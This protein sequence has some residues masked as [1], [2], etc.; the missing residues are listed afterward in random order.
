M[1]R[2]CVL[3]WKALA[4]ALVLA[5][6]LSLLPP[7]W[8]HDEAPAVAA[9]G[10]AKDMPRVPIVE[11]ADATFFDQLATRDEWFIDFYADWCGACRHFAPKLP[12]L[13]ERLSDADMAHVGLG[14]VEIEHN[15]NLAARFMITRLPTLVYI[16]NGQIRVYEGPLEAVKIFEFIQSDWKDAEV[17]DG[18][19]SPFSTFGT[20][21]GKVA[22]GGHRIIG[23]FKLVPLWGYLLICIALP[24]AAFYLLARDRPQPVVKKQQ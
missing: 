20:V 6:A 5:L 12:R 21:I 9:G 19:F 17:W 8:A 23:I 15:P 10:V 2:A 13:S 1:L 16:R 24:M 7:T 18:P 22:G 3:P 4:S 11:L 14:K